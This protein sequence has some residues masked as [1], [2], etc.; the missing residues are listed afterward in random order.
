[1]LARLGFQSDKERLAAACQNLYDL[2]HIYVSSTNT[3]LQLLNT[4][5]GTS[6]PTL[7]VKENFSIKE[8]LQLLVNALKDMQASMETKDK[9]VE[10]SI[11]HR[12]YAKIAGHITS[13]QDTVT[14]VKELYE[15]YKG[16]VNSIKCVLVAVMLKHD[17]V[18]DTVES[19]IGQLSSPA[20]SLRVSELLMDY[21]DIMKMLQ[22]NETP[23][24]TDG[25]SSSSG[26]SQQLKL[27]SLPSS[28]TLAFLQAILQG[29]RSIKK[30]LR[31]TAECLEE[32]FRVLKPPCDIFQAFVKTLQACMLEITDKKQET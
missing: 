28:S 12:L 2:V 27:R 32:A 31:I 25:S 3:I 21:A 30:S 20:L 23:G 7:A 5:L 19:A 26:T 29:H 18:P 8:N 1:M 15:S 14:A 22:Q 4:H 17:R 11:S 9:D 24:T 10:E 13:L 6:F 16:V